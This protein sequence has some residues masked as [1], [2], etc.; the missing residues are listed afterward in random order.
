MHKKLVDKV[1][2]CNSVECNSV[3]RSSAEECTENNDKVKIAD[4]N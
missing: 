2:E 4:E 3:E 1:T